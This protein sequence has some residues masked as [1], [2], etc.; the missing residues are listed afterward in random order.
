M[1][2][3]CKCNPT[4]RIFYTKGKCDFCGKLIKRIKIRKQ[5]QRNP[6][7]QDATRRAGSC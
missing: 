1:S 2:K 4:I 6:Q 7:T 5:W 3:Y